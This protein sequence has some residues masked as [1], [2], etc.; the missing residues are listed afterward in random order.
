MPLAY[1][2]WLLKMKAVGGYRQPGKSLPDNDKT[3]WM[4]I[5][6]YIVPYLFDYSAS[7]SAVLSAL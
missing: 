6:Y 2:P 3:T 4:M 5:P 1:K 7:S